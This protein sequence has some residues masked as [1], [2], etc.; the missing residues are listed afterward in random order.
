MTFDPI[1]W[2]GESNLDSI[3]DQPDYSSL[4]TYSEIT[5]PVSQPSR[6]QRVACFLITASLEFQRRERLLCARRPL[7]R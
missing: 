5:S 3:P 6:D 2:V 7:R 1:A 4:P